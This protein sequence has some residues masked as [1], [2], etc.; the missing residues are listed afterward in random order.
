[1]RW[2]VLSSD[3]LVFFPAVFYFIV[4]YYT[5]RNQSGR[6]YGRAW[7]IA[8]ILLNPCLILIDHG[9]FQYNCISLGLTVGAIAAIL[10]DKDLLACVLYSL[11]LNHKQ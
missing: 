1:M 7:H 5:G 9:H 10:S 3:A 2:T 4:V 11:A 6:M 8:I